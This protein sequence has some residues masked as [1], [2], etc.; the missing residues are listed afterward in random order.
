MFKLI[1]L[2]Q[3]TISVDVRYY[4]Q[5]FWKGNSIFFFSDRQKVNRIIL[6]SR[7]CYMSLRIWN[8]EM[9]DFYPE[10]EKEN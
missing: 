7:V 3:V 2:I 8:G 9:V 1:L 4:P 5:Y 10:K 6:Q